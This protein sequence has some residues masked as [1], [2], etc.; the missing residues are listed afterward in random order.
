[1]SKKHRGRF[2]KS[3]RAID[4]HEAERAN[5]TASRKAGTFAMHATTSEPMRLM[6]AKNRVA[7]LPSSTRSP[8]SVGCETSGTAVPTGHST[9]RL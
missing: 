9:N 5:A 2:Q 3:V 8:L 1:D 4:Q 7:K 6:T